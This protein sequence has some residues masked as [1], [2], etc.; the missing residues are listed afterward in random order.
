MN[1]EVLAEIKFEIYEAEL[2]I[3]AS[4]IKRTKLIYEVITRNVWKKLYFFSSLLVKSNPL[5]YFS[6]LKPF[7]AIRFL[8]Y[9]WHG[10]INTS[11]KN[12]TFVTHLNGKCHNVCVRFT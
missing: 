2:V 11:G 8:K 6:L 4:N 3:Q 10:E 7:N 1:S 5:K 9:E 12:Y